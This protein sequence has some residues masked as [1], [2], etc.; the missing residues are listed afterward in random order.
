MK[1][2]VSHDQH[3]T[4][5][6]SVVQRHWIRYGNKA[7]KSLKSATALKPH[8]IK[9]DSARFH[10]RFAEF[11]IGHLLTFQPLVSRTVWL[12]QSTEI[13][14]V[15]SGRAPSLCTQSPDCCLLHELAR[16]TA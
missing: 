10:K 15:S 13:K 2:L 16:E 1:A 9:A 4:V 3:F 14:Y 5:R 12:P 7:N 8:N 6:N 11:F